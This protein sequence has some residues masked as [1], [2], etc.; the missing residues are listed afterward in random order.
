MQRL[1]AKRLRRE[2]GA[3]LITPGLALDTE[4]T[5]ALFLD[6]A[7]DG[8]DIDERFA[9]RIPALVEALVTMAGP[10][11][12]RYG[13]TSRKRLAAFVTRRKLQFRKTGY[14]EPLLAYCLEA[15][16][17]RTRGTIRTKY[18]GEVVP[19]VRMPTGGDILVTRN[20][21]VMLH[22]RGPFKLF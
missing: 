5:E 6:A 12:L 17:N 1:G 16:K 20:V 11:R 2:L 15:T 18:R 21:Y 7:Y 9:A 3:A 10:P 14:F 19:C 4:L 8:Y 13:P 22:E